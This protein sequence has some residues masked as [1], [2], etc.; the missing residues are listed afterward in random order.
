MYYIYILISN[1]DNKLYV[2]FTNDLKRR[3]KQHNRGQVNST[4]GRRPLKLVYKEVCETKKAAIERERYLK[5]GCGQEF[6]KQI[7]NGKN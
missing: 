4:K 5:S 6:L 7:L 1:Y 2:G 3:L